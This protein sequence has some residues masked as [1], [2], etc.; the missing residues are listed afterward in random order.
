M[1]LTNVVEDFIQSPTD[2]LLEQ[3]TKEQLMKIAQYYSAEVE[4]KR[5]KENLKSIIKASLHLLN[6]KVVC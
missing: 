3:C 2:E 5:T 6:K 1:V 4:P